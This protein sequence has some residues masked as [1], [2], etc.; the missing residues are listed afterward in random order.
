MKRLLYFIVCLP[1]LGV[2]SQQPPAP[3]DSMALYFDEIQY[4]AQRNKQ[5]WNQPLYG[6]MLFIYP[7]TRQVFANYPDAAGVLKQ[8]GPV[9]T[10][11]FP[12]ERNIANTAV[13]WNGR[14]WA[15]VMLPLPNNKQDR[16]NLMAH[17][18]FHRAQLSLGFRLLDAANNHLDQKE[19]R[20]YLRL[21]LEA[22]KQAV[23][24][25][26]DR[27]AAMHVKNALAFRQYRHG[28]YAR[29]DSTENKLELNEGLA[30]YTGLLVANRNKEQT[31]AHFNEVLAGFLSNPGFV[32]SF[33]YQTVPMYGYLLQGKRPYWNHHV[34]VSTHLTK[35]FQD[36]FHY[37]AKTLSALAIQ[38]LMNNYDGNNIVVAETAREQNIKATIAAYK[39]KMVQDPHLE[40]PAMQMNVSFDPRTMIAVENAGTVYPIITI[41]DNWGTLNASKGALINTDWS[42]VSVSS[43]LV[44]TANSIEGEGWKLNLKEGYTLVKDSA[45]GNY[46]VQRK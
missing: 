4:A 39:K 44:N 19:G 46:S 15:M 45:T 3:A 6:P 17:E 29:A 2:W 11:Y 33:A 7:A 21:E 1:P 23:N 14:R 32:R 42:K 8:S 35:Y 16:I 31:V 30:E 37:S 38:A 5:L 20:I 36:A 27:V 9:Y 25:S 22:L 13:E 41:T 40:I 18:L 10:G 24:T 12:A 34:K 26:N 28:L 43:P